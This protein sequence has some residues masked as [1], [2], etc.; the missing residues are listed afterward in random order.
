MMEIINQILLLKYFFIL[1]VCVFSYMY[2]YAPLVC[3]HRGY[4]RI[5]GLLKL[6]Y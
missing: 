3:I 1:C 2:V 4:K 6:S 5:S